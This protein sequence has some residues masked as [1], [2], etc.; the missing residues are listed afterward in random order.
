MASSS[1]GWR[2]LPYA[3]LPVP[4]DGSNLI[5]E[6]LDPVG[7]A[8]H[9]HPVFLVSGVKGDWE[10]MRGEETQ[11]LGFARLEHD[12]T[13]V[14][15]RLVLLPGTHSKHAHLAG[16]CLCDFKT[17]MTG[18]LFQ[19]LSAHS[20]LRHSVGFGGSTIAAPANRPNEEV[21]PKSF[22]EGVQLG[23][24]QGLTSALFRVRTRQ[25]LHAC[26]AAENRSFL[27]GLLIG[28][29]LEALNRYS[30]SIPI[31]LCGGEHLTS[32]YRAALEALGWGS[33]LRVLEPEA[34][35]Q[36]TGLGQALILEQILRRSAV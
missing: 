25:V 17:F 9:S 7:S 36:L 23:F 21:Q 5:W 3:Q 33:R 1:I 30:A 26:A 20:V 34:A 28:S 12:S 6:E 13:Q 15:E 4:L 31:V 27:S 18:E 35:R 19:V 32:S 8:H 29:E 24:S 10:I 11:I 16:N 14:A 22:L 2:E